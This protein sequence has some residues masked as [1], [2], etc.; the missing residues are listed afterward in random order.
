METTNKECMEIISENETK[1]TEGIKEGGRQ[2]TRTRLQ[3]AKIV[4][5]VRDGKTQNF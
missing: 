2:K 3:R 5:R 4:W 1:W